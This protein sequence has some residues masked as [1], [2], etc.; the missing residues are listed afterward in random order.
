MIAAQTRAGLG[1]GPGHGK[2]PGEA[3]GFSR[4]SS[5]VDILPSGAPHHHLTPPTAPHAPAI[6]RGMST[7]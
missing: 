4:Q 5:H 7:L 6:R 2:W 1:S 3:D